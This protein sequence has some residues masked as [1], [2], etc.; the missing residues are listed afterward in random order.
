MITGM[1]AIVFSRRPDRSRAFCANVLA[2]PP[3]DAGGG[4]LI[5]A[6]PRPGLRFILT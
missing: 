5:L 1:H 2:M 4:R 6:L 3:A